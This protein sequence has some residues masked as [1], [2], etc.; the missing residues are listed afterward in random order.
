MKK[1]KVSFKEKMIN[2]FYEPIINKFICCS[3]DLAV[4][5]GYNG[6]LVD[7]TILFN[8]HLKSDD[9]VVIDITAL[10]SECVN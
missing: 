6:S 4:K 3:Y 2:R 1:N 7:Y 9:F 8:N 10:E 5:N